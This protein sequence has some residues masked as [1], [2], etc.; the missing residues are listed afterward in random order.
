MAKKSVAAKA[1][2]KAHEGRLTRLGWPSAEK[3]LA[4]ARSGKRKEVSSGLNL[5]ANFS[6][7]PSTRAKAKAIL[8]RVKALDKNAH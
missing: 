3:L 2:S 5:L 8:A 4:A 6:G 7:D 1:F